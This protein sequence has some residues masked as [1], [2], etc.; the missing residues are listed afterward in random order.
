M[1]VVFTPANQKGKTS[2]SV[3]LTD[4]Y[5][6]TLGSLTVKADVGQNAQPIQTPQGV[7]NLGFTEGSYPYLDT[8]LPY[9]ERVENLL[10]LL[11]PEEKEMFDFLRGG[12]YRLEQEKIPF[13][14]ASSKIPIIKK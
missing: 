3:E 7:V 10:S 11:T 8:R 14:Y 9:R 6:Q 1:M 12:N 2:R 4:N 5:G 13:E